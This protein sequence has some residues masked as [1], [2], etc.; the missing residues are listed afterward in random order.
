[1]SKKNHRTFQR[2]SWCGGESP[3]VEFR[4]RLDTCLAVYGYSLEGQAPVDADFQVALRLA[5]PCNL[6]QEVRSMSRKLLV[7]Q[8]RRQNPRP[9]QTNWEQHVQDANDKDRSQ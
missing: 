5:K 7:T 1:M 9:R 2:T 3:D 6:I 4:K 8:I